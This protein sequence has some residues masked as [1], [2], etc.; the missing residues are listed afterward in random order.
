MPSPRNRRRDKVSNFVRRGD[1]AWI[2]LDFIKEI[3][4]VGKDSDGIVSFRLVDV[5]G[6]VSDADSDFDPS[7]LA[8]VLPAQP[9]EALFEFYAQSTERLPSSRDIVM[10][11]IPI[12]GWRCTKW[13][14]P[15]TYKPYIRDR[16]ACTFLYRRAD[17][18]FQDPGAPQV[19]IES[20]EDAK[21]YALRVISSQFC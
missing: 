18:Q 21:N 16:G 8:P 17:G 19:K 5:E 3:R 4:P 20:L 2:N 11:E 1:G 9:G 13:A 14:T 15:V 6:V 7:E 12:L 10:I